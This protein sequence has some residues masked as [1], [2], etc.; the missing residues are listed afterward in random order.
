LLLKLGIKEVGMAK[1]CY[2]FILSGYVA[3]LTLYCH[4]EKEV[5]NLKT[6]HRGKNQL[7]F[8]QALVLPSFNDNCFLK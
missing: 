4:Q 6:I 1:N 5:I 7:V 2:K 8:F 3:L